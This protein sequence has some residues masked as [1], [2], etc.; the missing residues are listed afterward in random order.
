MASSLRPCRNPLPAGDVNRPSRKGR[1]SAVLIKATRN[2]EP[3]IISR[4]VRM[5]SAESPVSQFPG[6]ETVQEGD[7]QRPCCHVLNT[8]DLERRRAN[9]TS[10]EPRRSRAPENLRVATGAAVQLREGNPLDAAPRSQTATPVTCS[11][12]SQMD[13]PFPSPCR[14]Y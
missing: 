3:P 1:S 8:L 14:S 12:E 7:H 4:S 5:G 11:R 2:P 10:P 6:P 13:S 9:P